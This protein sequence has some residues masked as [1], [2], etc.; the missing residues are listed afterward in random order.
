MS[1]FRGSQ[2][3]ELTTRRPHAGLLRRERRALLEAREEEL[4][5]LGGLMVE[6]YRRNEYNDGLLAEVCVEV[7]AIDS[8]VEEIGDVLSDRRRASLCPCGTPILHGSH[9]CSHCG[10]NVAQTA[11]AP[12]PAHGLQ[13]AFA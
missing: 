8:R 3:S 5:K 1:T 2:E 4:R 13:A 10:S 6:M 11:P 9:Y 12:A 7:I